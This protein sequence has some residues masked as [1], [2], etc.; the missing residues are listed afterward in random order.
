MLGCRGDFGGT[1]THTCQL[2]NNIIPEYAF[3]L[4]F[5]HHKMTIRSLYP[6]SRNSGL[7]NRGLM[8]D[9]HNTIAVNNTHTAR[10]NFLTAETET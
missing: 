7:T 5:I 2:I 8:L 1:K 9:T 3:I 6:R 4:R 10:N